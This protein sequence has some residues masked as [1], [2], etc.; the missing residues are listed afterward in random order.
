LPYTT[1]FRSAAAQVAARAPPLHRAAW[2]W[3]HPL[4][5]GGLP[6]QFAVAAL[7][8]RGQRADRR[9]RRPPPAVARLGAAALAAQPGSLALPRGGRPLVEPLVRAAAGRPAAR[10]G[11]ARLGILA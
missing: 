11:A 1:L 10:A 5:G 8:V 2:R 3:R 6:A 9:A 7:C 4:R